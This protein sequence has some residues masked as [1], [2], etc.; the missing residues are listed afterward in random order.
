MEIWAQIVYMGY[1]D[2]NTTCESIVCQTLVIERHYKPLISKQVTTCFKESKSVLK[3]RR[4]LIYRN[5][6]I[7][8]QSQIKQLCPR[9]VLAPEKTLSRVMAYLP[10]VASVKVSKEKTG[11]RLIRYVH[12]ESS[13]VAHEVTRPFPACIAITFCGQ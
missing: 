4:Q 3:L 2:V 12:R 13:H 10:I 7:G 1:C 6:V 9:A 8:L 5:R 11:F